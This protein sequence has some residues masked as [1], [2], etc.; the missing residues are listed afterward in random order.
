[1]TEFKIQQSVFEATTATQSD[2]PH[3]HVRVATTDPTQS[4][5]EFK[6]NHEQSHVEVVTAF[7]EAITAGD[8]N[9]MEA[10]M[11]EDFIW[12]LLPATLGVPAKN[13]RQYLLQSKDLGRI[14]AFLKVRGRQY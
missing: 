4:P 5:T 9:G 3:S 11:T 8:I 14:F 2:P 1:M 7:M 6:P 12:R 10:L 13:K